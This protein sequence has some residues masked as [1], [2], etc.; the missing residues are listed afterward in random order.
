MTETRV[1]LILVMGKPPLR[2]L[3]DVTL[4]CGDGEFVVIRRC[5]VF[6]KSGEP[7]WANL[8]LLSIEK[9]GRRHLRPLIELPDGLKKRVLK[10]ILEE[11][12]R[13]PR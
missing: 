8:P 4:R 3:A 12:V 1:D 13:H 11:Y 7:P 10:A 9:N 5:T 2:A 6:E